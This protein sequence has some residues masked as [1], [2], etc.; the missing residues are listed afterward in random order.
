[1]STE[2]GEKEF[3]KFAVITENNAILRV[4]IRI[5]K[6]NFVQG[7]L[8]GEWENVLVYYAAKSIVDHQKLTLDELTYYVT[9]MAGPNAK[10][11]DVKNLIVD[12]K[13]IWASL[14]G[15]SVDVVASQF[16]ALR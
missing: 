4:D 14:E 13:D 11:E 3:R 16:A 8:F 10:H 2:V 12:L 5:W 15:Q 9:A 7:G 1:V 6:R